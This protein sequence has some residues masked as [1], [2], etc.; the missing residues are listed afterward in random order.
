[1]KLCFFWA[2]L[3]LSASFLNCNSSHADE[4]LDRLNALPGVRAI[5]ITQPEDPPAGR[6]RFQVD[7]TQAVDHFSS[8]SE[9]F[10]QRLIISHRGF[11]EP[12]V[13]RTGG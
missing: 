7:L 13:L 2:A 4:I 5:D 12:V 1:M 11:D 3:V 9:T 10:S 8:G 6:H